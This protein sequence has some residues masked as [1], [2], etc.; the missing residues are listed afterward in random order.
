MGKQPFFGSVRF[1]KVLIISVYAFL[2]ITPLIFAAVF[3]GLY[4]GQKT[5]N[6]DLSADLSR[7]EVGFESQSALLKALGVEAEPPR[8]N[9]DGSEIPDSTDVPDTDD[10]TTNNINNE[11]TASTDNTDN[12]DSTGAETTIEDGFIQ[13]DPTER[14]T[15]AVN[16][17]TTRTSANKPATTRNEDDFV[18]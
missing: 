4:N 10:I 8:T 5:V 12:T 7:L 6:S 18:K 17:Y 14:T 3:A 13:T 15:T 16:K 11:D 9:P 1:F 2:L